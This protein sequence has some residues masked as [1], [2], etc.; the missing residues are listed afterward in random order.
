MGT[1]KEVPSLPGGSLPKLPGTFLDLATFFN[2][3]L[4]SSSGD[5]FVLCWLK[6]TAEQVVHVLCVEDISQVHQSLA[7]IPFDPSNNVFEN[8]TDKNI[9]F[10]EKSQPA[11]EEGDHG[12]KSDELNAVRLIARLA[13]ANTRSESKMDA[14]IL[15]FRCWKVAMRIFIRLLKNWTLT[16]MAALTVPHNHGKLDLGT[17]D[18]HVFE[19]MPNPFQDNQAFYQQREMLKANFYNAVVDGIE[20]SYCGIPFDPPVVHGRSVEWD[21]EGRTIPFPMFAHYYNKTRFGTEHVD[22]P[23]L[24]VHVHSPIHQ[25]NVILY[26]DKLNEFATVMARIAIGLQLL[27]KMVHT[28]DEIGRS[29]NSDSLWYLNTGEESRGL[30][31]QLEQ[32]QI[33]LTNTCMEW[34]RQP[35]QQCLST[36]LHGASRLPQHAEMFFLAKR[37]EEIRIKQSRTENEDSIKNTDAGNVIGNPI[38]ELMRGP[39][40]NPEAP[41]FMPQVGSIE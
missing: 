38:E 37:D 4:K 39:Y 35:S 9:A 10:L 3:W 25:D 8:S 15:H 6:Q 34:S 41:A 21:R 7:S 12:R 5:H 19:Q 24:M 17:T 20:C 26:R 33:T 36:V 11:F 2:E 1:E 18:R 27:S 28:C 13:N 30:K 22:H 40:L 31:S 14:A 32:A 16:K 23:G 29:D